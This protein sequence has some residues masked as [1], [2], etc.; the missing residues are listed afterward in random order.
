MK[1]WDDIWLNESFATFMAYKAIDAAHP[2]WAIWDQFVSG[3]TRAESLAGAMNLDFLMNTHPIQVQVNSP[4]EIEQIF[5]PISYGK[6]AHVLQM[7]ESYVGEDAFR[8]GVRRYLSAH[9]YSNATGNDLWTSIG[10]ASGK[11]VPKIMSSW[12]RQAGFPLVTVTLHDNKLSLTQNR[13]ILSGDS[14]KTTWPIPITLEM[15]GERKNILMETEGLE[16]DAKNLKT[17]KVNPDRTAFYAIQLKGV[18]EIV[19]RSKLSTYDRWGIAFDTFLLLLS[20]KITFDE[21]LTTLE[22]FRNE[23]N[24]LPI[25][26]IS[27]QLALLHSLAPDPMTDVSKSFHRSF[28]ETLE[29]KDDELSSTLRGTV[30]LRLA[31]VDE[32]YAAQL[33]REFTTYNQVQ[34]D[35]RHSVAAAYAR[36]TNDLDGLMKSYRNTDSEEDKLRLLDA[37]TTFKDS[38]LVERTLNFAI[39]NE[40]K[41]QNVL[42]AVHEAS[43]NPYTKPTV[44]GWLQANIGKLQELY[45]GTGVLSGVLFSIIPIIGVGRVQE[46]EAFFDKNKVPDADMGI[47]AGLEKLRAYDRLARSMG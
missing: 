16:I 41:R 20:G 6:G 31:M 38:N 27:N 15:N 25:E 33:A 45:R 8:E 24:R 34:P 1:W 12:T 3:D 43:E 21:Y 36:T 28:L 39:S 14:T 44:W 4:D 32:D 47:N 19:W 35:M 22:R 13:L 37:M 30:A 10:E 18:E 5:D 23:D 11:Q 26:E 29:D 46:V 42:G 2:E 17:L 7:I 9:A 40:V